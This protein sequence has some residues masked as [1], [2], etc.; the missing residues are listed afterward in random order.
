MPFGYVES[1]L[2]VPLTS[3]VALRVHWRLVRMRVAFDRVEQVWM[4]SRIMS[5]RVLDTR[6]EVNSGSTLT[7]GIEFRP[8]R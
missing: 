1:G 7:V 2:G 3:R 4:D 8:S 5:E 6:W